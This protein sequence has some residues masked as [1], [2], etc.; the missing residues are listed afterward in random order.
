MVGLPERLVYGY[1]P[2]KWRDFGIIAVDR[3]VILDAAMD[4]AHW[5]LELR[6][7]ERVRAYGPKVDPVNA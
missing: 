1:H 7:P 2:F 5:A 4:L 6:N 3:W